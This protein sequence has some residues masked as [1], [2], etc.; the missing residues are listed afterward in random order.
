MIHQRPCSQA[1]H[2][3]GRMKRLLA[4]KPGVMCECRRSSK[5]LR[6]VPFRRGRLCRV[7]HYSTSWEPFRIASGDAYTKNRFLT[8]VPPHRSDLSCADGLWPEFT[9]LS[10]FEWRWSPNSVWPFCSKLR[11]VTTQMETTGSWLREGNFGLL[12]K[13]KSVLCLTR[14]CKYVCVSWC[15]TI[16]L[17]NCYLLLSVCVNC[18]CS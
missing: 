13:G 1:W 4:G 10:A 12:Y 17:L 8:T 14:Q 9:L 6:R 16:W 18:S 7:W 11:F 3:C 15:V 5:T 2:L